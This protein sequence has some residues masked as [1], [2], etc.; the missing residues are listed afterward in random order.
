M[1]GWHVSGNRSPAPLF[2]KNRLS[3][4]GGGRPCR[5]F[6]TAWFGRDPLGEALDFR[7]GEEFFNS[8]PS[9]FQFLF[10]EQH[11][12]LRVAGAADADGLAHETALE[13]PFVPFVAVAGSRNEMMARESLDA[14]AN[15]TGALHKVPLNDH[16]AV[17]RGV[18]LLFNGPLP[19]P[20]PH[21]G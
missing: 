8:V 9:A 18:C 16:P 1:E 13:F 14:L 3:P 19:S 10:R 17:C 4:L 12:D 6:E 11:M 2:T 5:A 20:W 7:M 15:R 21:S